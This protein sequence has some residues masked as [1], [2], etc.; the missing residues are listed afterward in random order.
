MNAIAWATLGIAV[1][2]IVVAVAE[3]YIRGR[4]MRD[5]VEGEDGLH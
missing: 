5:S 2:V 1:L 4:E 3:G